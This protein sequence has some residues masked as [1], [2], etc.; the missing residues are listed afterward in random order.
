MSFYRTKFISEYYT[1]LESMKSKKISKDDFVDF[2]IN[3]NI[4]LVRCKDG[5]YCLA[6]GGEEKVNV[7]IDIVEMLT[8]KTLKPKKSDIVVLSVEKATD[9]TITTKSGKKITFIT[10]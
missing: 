1:M 7:D 3:S 10:D 2:F 4:G 8:G 6:I 9:E 5:T